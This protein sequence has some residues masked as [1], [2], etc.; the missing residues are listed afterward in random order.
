MIQRDIAIDQ[1]TIPEEFFLWIHS[2]ITEPIKGFEHKQNPDGSFYSL[3]Q[4]IE[5]TRKQAI[6]IVHDFLRRG[7]SEADI[8]EILYLFKA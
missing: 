5:A 3:T 6:V 7:K 4:Q 1:F 8:F 2:Q